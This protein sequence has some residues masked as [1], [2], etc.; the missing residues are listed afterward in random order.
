MVR[1][2]DGSNQR[3]ILEATKSRRFGFRYW[4]SWKIFGHDGND[5]IHGGDKGDTLYG[6]GG[7]DL[8]YGNNGH[9]LIY[10]D[11][12]ADTSYGGDH[13]DTL[14]G[15]SHNDYLNGENGNDYLYGGSGE[16]TV[17]GSFGND[18]LDGGSG[19]DDL[20]GGNGNDYYYIVADAYG[21]VK[22][23][24]FEYN[25]INGGFDTVELKGASGWGMDAGVENV[26]FTWTPW[27]GAVG[28][29]NDL[30]N[31]IE[32]WHFDDKLYGNWGS[33]SLIG[34]LGND[35]LDGGVGHD[36]LKG[37]KGNDT[38]VGGE[39][40]WG[41]LDKDHLMGFGHGANEYDVLSGAGGSD[42]F[43]LGDN[44]DVFYMDAGYA[45]IKD[46]NIHGQDDFVHLRGSSSW[47]S[48]DNT[49]DFTGNGQ[50]D[51]QILRLGN[52]VGVLE[53]VTNFSLT[54]DAVY[55]TQF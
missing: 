41:T 1:T 32:G 25:G 28:Y 27:T 5:D 21:E 35:Y 12:G 37:G 51:T 42:H 24:V 14:Y 47:Y 50:L 23:N 54:Q 18:Y 49:A 10:G 38:L 52:V 3:D 45:I 39:G 7:L 48:T 40:M 36:T 53:G 15:G 29:G 16:D 46:F 9:D 2:L 20:Y 19:T 11:N 6:G 55:N 4:E 34:G 22:D 44:K 33:D 8:I 30:N 13:N 31:T 26:K 43:Y 17:V